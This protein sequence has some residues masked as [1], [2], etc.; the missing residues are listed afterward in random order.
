MQEHKV[1]V[2]FLGYT[3][4]CLLLCCG[5]VWLESAIVYSGYFTRFKVWF[6][7]TLYYVLKRWFNYCYQP[8]KSGKKL[9]KAEKE[10]QKKE[11][12]EKQ[13]QERG[14]ICSISIFTFIYVYNFIDYE[15]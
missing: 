13:E 9:S 10:K 1:A 2:L 15:T 8:P 14:N 12:E 7:V 5:C 3:F 4:A 6:E 11:M